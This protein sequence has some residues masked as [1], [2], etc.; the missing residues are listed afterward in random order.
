MENEY[1]NGKIYRIDVGEDFYIGSTKNTLHQRKAGH[2]NDL[3][4]LTRNSK[5]YVK[6]RE[7]GLDFTMVDL[8]LVKNFP[9]QSKTKL[10]REEGRF[11]KEMDSTLNMT[12]AGRTLNEYYQDNKDTI[13]ENTRN[14]AL[15]NKEQV[16][17]YQANYREENKE[18]IQGYKQEYHQNHKEKNNEYNRQYWE[19]HK[20]ELNERRKQKTTCLYCDKELNKGSMKRHHKICPDRPS[21]SS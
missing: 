14:Y 17:E 15:L 8:T 12:I 9:C 18:K 13:K 2:Q 1:I 7:L 16:A 6:M 3:L 5:L 10:E 11:Q 20:D 21:S 4:D 19:E